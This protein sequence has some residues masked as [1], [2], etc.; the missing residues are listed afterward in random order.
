MI[1]IPLQLSTTEY[2]LFI[3]LEDDNIDRIVKDR[4]PAEIRSSAMGSFARKKI[5]NINI[6]YAT[7]EEAKLLPTCRTVGEVAKFL[8]NLG[9]GWSFRPEMGD[10][11]EAYQ[12]PGKN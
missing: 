5:R 11:D 8:M 3:V 2:D 4:D 7:P 9:R 1:T 10:N 6:V 12:T